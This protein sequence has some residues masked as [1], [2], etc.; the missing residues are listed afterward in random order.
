MPFSL[1][2]PAQET[3]SPQNGNERTSSLPL[4]LDLH[5]NQRMDRPAATNQ[6]V[7]DTGTGSQPVWTVPGHGWDE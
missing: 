4:P 2:N 6:R 1:K 5:A 7:G 3:P